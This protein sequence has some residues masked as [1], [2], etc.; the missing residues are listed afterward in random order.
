MMSENDDLLDLDGGDL[1]LGKGL[2]PGALPPLYTLKLSHNIADNDSTKNRSDD[3]I[4]DRSM[5]ASHNENA[6]EYQTHSQTWQC[7]ANYNPESENEQDLPNTDEQQCKY[8]HSP[9]TTSSNSMSSSPSK[10]V[11]DTIHKVFGS[12]PD[13][14][15]KNGKAND[16]GQRALM[17]LSQ[18]SEK[19]KLLRKTKSDGQ[20]HFDP[21]DFDDN[22]DTKDMKIGT[23]FSQ[24]KSLFQRDVHQ[25]LHVNAS[26][27]KTK[28][29]KQSTK[30]TSQGNDDLCD[31]YF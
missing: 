15:T 13:T 26:G 10:S 1:G 6:N 20:M 2:K 19:I 8:C 24:Q 7:S 4:P 14:I 28:S 17:K 16:F 5:S 9:L 23:S 3:R 27:D 30:N 11:V 22:S 29:N 31:I 18:V 25:I 12:Q 21:L